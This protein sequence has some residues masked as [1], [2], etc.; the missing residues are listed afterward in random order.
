M[1][2]KLNR[3]D[4]KGVGVVAT[5]PEGTK[6]YYFY[7]DMSDSKGIER[8]ERHGQYFVDLGRWSKVEYIYKSSEYVYFVDWLAE[9]DSFCMSWFYIRYCKAHNYKFYDYL[10]QFRA[11][12]DNKVYKFD[13]R[14][15]IDHISEVIK[16]A[17]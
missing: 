2:N 9:K 17:V 12:I 8:A 1:I 11:V 6:Q 16:I 14:P 3:D 13:Y 7:E 5:T 15:S 10:Q 4:L